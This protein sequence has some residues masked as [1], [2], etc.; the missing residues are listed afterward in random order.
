VQ[1]VSLAQW[2]AMDEWERLLADTYCG[3]CQEEIDRERVEAQQQA[4]RDRWDDL[5]PTIE[6][7][8]KILAN[9]D[10]Y[11]ILDTET[12]GLEYN[13]RI[14]EIAVTTA[15][16][17]VLLDTLVNPGE[18]IPADATAI[19]KITDEMVANAPSLLRNPPQPH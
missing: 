13:S 6:W 14:V 7:A 17:E 19:H 4:D 5:G 11:A 9:P 10:A 15:D 16:G 8:Q 2:A 12:T 1:V 18:P 3:R